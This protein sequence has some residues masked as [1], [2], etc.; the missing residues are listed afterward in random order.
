MSGATFGRKGLAGGIAAPRRAPAFGAAA[1]AQPP[2]SPDEEMAARRDAFL[3]AERARSG[4]AAAAPAATQVQQQKIERLARALTPRPPETF[5]AKSYPV[6]LLLWM[7]LGVAGAHRLYLGRR[8]SGGILA[9]MFTV[10]V[11][12]LATGYYPAFLGLV[13]CTLWM[14]ADGRL[15]GRM[16]KARRR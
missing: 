10:S 8:I 7:L 12:L 11:G 5:E 3:A 2:L 6:A 15:I 13:A 16:S 1:P 9:A 4:G 14:L